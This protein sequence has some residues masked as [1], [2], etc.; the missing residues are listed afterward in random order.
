M[1]TDDGLIWFKEQLLFKIEKYTPSVLL[2]WYS[3]ERADCRREEVFGFKAQRK[4]KMDGKT[5][6]R[7]GREWDFFDHKYHLIQTGFYKIQK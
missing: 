1:E 6:Y 3:C 4:W 7:Y 5:R 2:N